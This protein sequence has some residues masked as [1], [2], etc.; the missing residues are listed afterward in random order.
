M[1]EENHIFANMKQAWLFYLGCM[2]VGAL[3]AQGSA[4][5]LIYRISAAECQ[6]LLTDEQPDATFLQGRTPVD[7]LWQPLV[8]DT[9]PLGHYAVVKVVAENV[10]TYTFSSNDHQVFLHEDP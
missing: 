2:V 5:S 9:F 6:R 4:H 1:T 7:T 3:H 10:H 8:A